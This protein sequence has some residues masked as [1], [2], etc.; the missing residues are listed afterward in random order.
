[1]Q[2]IK[3]SELKPHPQNNYF[4]DDITG[5]KWKDILESISRR[6]VIEP[7]VITQDKVIVSGHQ[8]VRACNELKINEV[9]CEIRI[10]QDD[11]KHSKEDKILEDL[12]S[13][14]IMQRGIGNTNPLKL[15]RCIQELERIKGVRQGKGG[16]RNPNGN[17][18]YGS[19]DKM[20]IDQNPQITQE[21]IAKQ[22]GV[23][24]KK[25]Q[26][27]KSLLELPED[28]QRLIETGVLDNVSLAK[29]ISEG[30]NEEQLED[31]IQFLTD[32]GFI[33]V[34]SQIFEK[35][36]NSL[37]KSKQ[38]EIA[39]MQNEITNLKNDIGSLEKERINLNNQIKTAKESGRQ[40]E[41][42]RLQPKLDKANRDIEE[43]EEL[44]K[45]LNKYNL[46]EKE[47]D[48]ANIKFEQSSQSITLAVEV[49]YNVQKIISE[50]SKLK[51]SDLYNNS[52]EVVYR[53][54]VLKIVYLAQNELNKIINELSPNE[55]VSTYNNQDII[56]GVY[57]HE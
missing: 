52:D 22:F 54:S 50:I 19:N 46:T 4:F 30:L 14:N 5:D 16:D 44:I 43:K 20:S 37:Q 36:R 24:V 29:R 15:A 53:D 57:Y 17:N 8:R 13:T 38:Q 51:I 33:K 35:F 55:K 3:V 39:H 12:I 9:L 41:I 1:M 27:I 48:T 40:E 2:L 45:K 10:Y 56:E 28:I 26:R 23:S 47:I 32:N 6:G 34:T 42:K 7:V 21:D 18:Q 25:V 11:D 49:E 31:F